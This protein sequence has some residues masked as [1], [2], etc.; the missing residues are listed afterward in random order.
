MLK[1][2]HTCMMRFFQA[3][4]RKIEFR[5]GATYT[6]K[7]LK[8]AFDLASTVAER[9]PGMSTLSYTLVLTDGMSTNR[10]LTEDK[11][12]QLKRSSQVIA[13]GICNIKTLFHFQTS[14][15]T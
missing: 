9:R 7:G 2:L 10:K 1:T 14:T 12:S 13:I 11:A 3:A 4:I 8:L 6:H 5:P 15:Y